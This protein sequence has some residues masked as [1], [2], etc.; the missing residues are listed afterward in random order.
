MQKTTESRLVRSCLWQRVNG[1]AVERFELRG[2]EGRWVLGGTIVA[3]HRRGPTE[4][5][6][7]VF[8]DAAWRTQ[9]TLVS[10]RDAAGERSLRLTTRNRRWYVNGREQSSLRG[11]VDVDLEWSPSTNTL[12][13]RRL[14]LPVGERSVMLDMAWIRFPALTIERLQQT[15]ERLSRARYRYVSGGGTFTADIE[16]DVAGLVADYKGGWRR[17]E[18]PR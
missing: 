6:Y 5:R 13:I 8:C 11:C 14:R 17:I 4:A 15:Y 1:V 2:A 16:V 12:P 10:V 3:I 9:R 18:A 7:Q